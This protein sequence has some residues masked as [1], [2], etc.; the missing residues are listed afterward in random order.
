ME[1]QQAMQELNKG[2]ISPVYCLLGSE[3]YLRNQFID[4]LHSLL[5][6]IDSNDISRLD[7]NELTV[8]DLLDEADTFSF[9]SEYRVIY[10]NNVQFLSAS[11]KQKLTDSQQKRL[12]EYLSNPN[13]SSIILFIIENDQ[14]D[15]RKKISKEIMKKTKLIDV[16]RLDEGQVSRYIQRFLENEASKYSREAVSELLLRVNYD[17]TSAMNEIIKL[18]VYSQSKITINIDTVRQLVPRTLESDVFQL[19]N[20]VAAKQINRATQIYKDLLLMKNE[21]IGLH[22]L[23]I[24]Q[25]RIIVQ[26]LILR[27]QGLNQGD[28]AKQLKVHPY[29][30][31]LAIESGSSMQLTELLNFYVELAEVDYYMKTG[32]GNKENYFYILLTKINNI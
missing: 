15:K 3:S 27:Q 6:D 5:G 9:F 24:S 16:T 12:I 11:S 4:K 14:I 8:D 32:I 21:P 22:A 28:I 23:L 26:S 10:V 17:L 1:L 31:K 18:N 19:T 7:M 25:F 29:R 13:P 30:V 20:A 2:L